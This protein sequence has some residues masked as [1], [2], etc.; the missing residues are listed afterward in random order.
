MARRTNVN[1]GITATARTSRAFAD[2][3]RNMRGLRME[4]GRMTSGMRRNRRV[5]Q[6]AGMQLSDFAVQVGGG[7]SAILAFTQNAPQFIQNF[8]AMGGALAAFVTIAG[9][10]AL[11]MTRTGQ[12]LNDLTPIAGV[13]QS[14]FEGLVRIFGQVKELTIDMANAVVNN[15]D[16]VLVYVA[17]FLGLMAGRWVATFILANGVVGTLS[18][19][20][21]ALRVILRSFLLI[22]AFVVFAEAIFTFVKLIKITGSFGGALEKLRPLVGAVGEFIRSTFVTAGAWMQ[23]AFEGAIASILGALAS[24]DSFLTEMLRGSLKGLVAVTA[25]LTDR[26]MSHLTQ[27]LDSVSTSFTSAGEAAERWRQASADSALRAADH[28]Q[29]VG[30]AGR[31]VVS[32]F[33]SLRELVA[34]GGS[35]IDIRNWF[36]GI[37]EAGDATEKTKDKVKSL[38]D[39]ITG[40]FKGGFDRLFDSIFEGGRKAIEVVRD[41]GLEI[42]K[43]VAKQSFFRA[44]ASA[45]PGTFGSGGFIDLL[46]NANGNAF[47]KGKVTPFKRGGV[48]NGPTTFP[49]RSGMGMMGEAG[50]EAIMPLTRRG[51][52]LG[53]DASGMAS[54]TNI[55]IENYS[56]AQI[57]YEPVTEGGVTRHRFVAREV[58]RA[59]QT[60]AGDKAMKGRFGLGAQGRKR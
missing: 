2:T 59:L 50:P 46:K 45:F 37:E 43:M 54:P 22:G 12:S 17:A 27:Q 48:V 34:S 36:K 38:K 53:V 55:S 23:S 21:V 9:T 44:L 18:K 19:A 42:T 24:L 11:V 52:R 26:D 15:L 25:F 32:E 57:T 4:Q 5:I 10:L 13:L 3:R 20:L 29:E 51:G 35:D 8:G 7:Q 41:L 49:M 31:R 56:S 28:L 60:G 47:S 33:K 16:R 14:E 58:D 1:V 30:E 39:Q 40:A 6:Q